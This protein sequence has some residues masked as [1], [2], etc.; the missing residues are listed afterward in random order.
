M[1][2][3]FHAYNLVSELTVVT[4]SWVAMSVETFTDALVTVSPLGKVTVPSTMFVYSGPSLTSTV[5][6]L[7][8]SLNV[9]TLAAPAIGEI[10][11]KHAKTNA[12]VVVLLSFMGPPS[13]VLQTC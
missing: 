2:P 9:V 8:P 13:F 12:V 5:T 4:S 1:K 7:L 10:N 3:G 11:I 6:S